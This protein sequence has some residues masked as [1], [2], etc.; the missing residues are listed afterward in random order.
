[1]REIILDIFY[2]TVVVACLAV[3]V[4]MM[5]TSKEN[6]DVLTQEYAD[7]MVEAETSMADSEITKY[8]GCELTGLEVRNIIST[9]KEYQYNLNV[10]INEDSFSY[11]IVNRGTTFKDVYKRF[12]YF[13]KRE[14]VIDDSTLSRTLA[15]WYEDN[16]TRCHAKLVA[17][18]SDLFEDVAAENGT[19]V[20]EYDS[21]TKRLPTEIT[22]ILKD[23]AVSG[24]EY[25]ATKLE[26][27]AVSDIGADDVAN[28]DSLGPNGELI[29][30]M[31]FS[32]LFKYK[33]YPLYNSD[34]RWV[35]GL[36][37]DYTE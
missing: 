27:V 10:K 17:G 2:V 19:S 20:S 5:V 16:N 23:K 22:P 21:L 26:R 11:V 36:A 8:A 15:V 29:E 7:Q 6:T 18:D 32:P 14:I 37:F 12:A 9:Y 13:L 30:N 25:K 3:F 34:G 28:D 4:N 1:M 24:E 35:T 33:A 31:I